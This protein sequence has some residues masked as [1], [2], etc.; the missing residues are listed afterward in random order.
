[1][2]RQRKQ[3][4]LYKREV[5]PKAEQHASMKILA[6]GS[7]R[8]ERQ[9]VGSVSSVTSTPEPAE[10]SQDVLNHSSFNG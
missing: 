3:G 7:S 2:S 10:A 1:M 8:W 5:V 4:R 9:G 6:D